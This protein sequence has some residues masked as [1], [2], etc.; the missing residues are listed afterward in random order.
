MSIKVVGIPGSLRKD[1][2][3]EVFCAPLVA[4]TEVEIQIFTR[5]GEIGDVPSRRGKGQ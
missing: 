5:L 1:L 4:P 2:S 3:T